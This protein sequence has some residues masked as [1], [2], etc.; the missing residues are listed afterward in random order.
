M[1]MSRI[2]VGT[3]KLGVPDYGFSS[4]ST[5]NHSKEFSS[6]EFLNSCS[7]LGVTHLDTSPRYGNAEAII[8]QYLNSHA[9]AFKVSSKVDNLTAA[10]PDSEAKVIASIRQSL[11][12]LNV[13]SLDVCYLHQNDLE[14]ITD[15]NI[16]K[17]L[18]KAKDLGLIK[19][20]GVSI[21]SDAE[22]AYACES[23]V[24]DVIQLPVSVFDLSFF[25]KFVEPKKYNKGF[26]ARSLLLQGI[27]TNRSEIKTRIKQH[28]E[29]SAYLTE[30]DQLAENNNMKTLEMCMRFT[31]SLQGIQQF[32]VGT[33]SIQNLKLNL[34]FENL[35]LKD[36]IYNT[37]Y[38]MGSRP[39]VWTNPRNW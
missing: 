18:L 30:L 14:I 8:G 2:A 19:Q 37:I 15:S 22:C 39:K 12:R 34:S 27:L 20:A 25:K 35:P 21:Y 1:N 31:F 32:I 26:I 9:G 7:A 16:Q 38:E 5:N 24:Y 23:P 3:V 13:D 33:T 17:G 4:A 28:T 36:E 6:S 10:S 11:K 29:V